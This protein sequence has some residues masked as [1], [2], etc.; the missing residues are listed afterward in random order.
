VQILKRMLRQKAVYWEHRGVN[1][2]SEP[3]QSEP[4]EIRCRW[5]D[6]ASIVTDQEGRE[7]TYNSTVYVDQDVKREGYLWLGRIQNLPGPWPPPSD[8]LR[9]QKFEKIPT[10]NAKKFLR[11]AYL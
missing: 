7:T 1:K 9:I 2:N 4:V 10:F 11:I 8:A 3:M 5:E 6:M